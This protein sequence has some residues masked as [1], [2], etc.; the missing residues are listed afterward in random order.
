MRA[1]LICIF[2]AAACDPT[3]V[4]GDP[5]P[6]CPQTAHVKRQLRGAWIATVTNIDWPSRPGMPQNQ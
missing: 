5:T 1:S 4:T 6:A 2:L 3:R